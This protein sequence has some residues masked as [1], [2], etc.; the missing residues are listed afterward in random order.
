M[1]AELQL[2]F[3]ILIYKYTAMSS[4]GYICLF[5]LLYFLAEPLLDAWYLLVFRKHKFK[6]IKEMST[7]TNLMLH[8]Q[9]I[10]YE[11]QDGEWIVLLVQKS[12]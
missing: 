3:G 1:A 2:G 9:Y 6:S 4:I 5:L 8:R 7:T 11:H 10:S 12:F